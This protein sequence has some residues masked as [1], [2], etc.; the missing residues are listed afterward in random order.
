MLR[1]IILG[2]NLEKGHC[3][4]NFV[5]N[6]FGTFTGRHHFKQRASNCN[7]IACIRRNQ[8]Y[9]HQCLGIMRNFN[10]LTDSKPWI[11]LRHLHVGSRG[12]SST[13]NCTGFSKYDVFDIQIYTASH[14]PKY[15]VFVTDW[16]CSVAAVLVSWQPTFICTAA[17][18]TCGEVPDRRWLRLL[19][20]G[21]FS[22]LTFNSWIGTQSLEMQSKTRRFK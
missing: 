6:M 7:G 5:L 21:L 4:S 18:S 16:G 20:G 2:E 9:I 1:W 22:T 15:D 8:V 13:R 17:T 3:S 14:F 19:L 11:T 10:G 12:A